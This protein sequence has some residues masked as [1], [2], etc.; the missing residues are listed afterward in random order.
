MNIEMRCRAALAVTIG[1]VSV[2]ALRT[3]GGV[4]RRRF[5]QSNGKE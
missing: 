2:A 5:W 1:A 3:D 4:F